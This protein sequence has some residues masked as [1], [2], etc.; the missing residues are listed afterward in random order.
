MKAWVTTGLVCGSVLLSALISL[1]TAAATRPKFGEYLQSYYT[2]AERRCS[3]LGDAEAG[4]CFEAAR[5]LRDQRIAEVVRSA[6]DPIGAEYQRA[7]LKYRAARCDDIGGSTGSGAGT[8]TAECMLDMAIARQLEL[9]GTSE[10]S[11]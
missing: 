7:W 5:R 11:I 3:G 6:N 9:Q 2:A 10:G 8:I 1:P 4:W